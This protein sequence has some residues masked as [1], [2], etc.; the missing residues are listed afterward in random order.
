MKYINIKKTRRNGLPACTEIT[1][2]VPMDS[3]D[4]VNKHLTP[5]FCPAPSVIYHPAN[6]TSVNIGYLMVI[7]MDISV[8]NVSRQLAGGT[9][10]ALGMTY[11]RKVRHRQNN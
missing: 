10:K 1:E 11:F 4:D 7:F 6:E 2:R 5:N 8:K 9:G 3:D